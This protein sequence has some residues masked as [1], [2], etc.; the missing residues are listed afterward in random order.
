MNYYKKLDLWKESMELGID[1]YKLALKFPKEEMFAL[2]SQIKRCSISIPSNIAEGAG[3]NGKNEF[4]NFLG[5]A[6][7]SCCE[8]DTQLIIALKLGYIQST[9][10]SIVLDRLDHIQRMLVNLIK[11]LKEKT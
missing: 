10:C 8:L 7:G 9:E 1:V 5:I 3:R 11:K 4:I 6:G 2:T